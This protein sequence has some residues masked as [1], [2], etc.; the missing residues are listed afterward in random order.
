MNKK[1]YK[2][3]YA[4]GAVAATIAILFGQA[5]LTLL[6]FSWFNLKLTIWQCLL[7]IVLIKSITAVVDKDS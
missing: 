6:I 4:I 2:T 1:G 7:I 5:W 3:G